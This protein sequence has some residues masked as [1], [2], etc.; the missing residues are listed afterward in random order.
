LLAYLQPPQH[1]YSVVPEPEYA[2]QDKAIVVRVIHERSL[3][4][5]DRIET[6]KRE[7]V[8]EIAIPQIDP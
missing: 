5:R 6:L 1:I 2:F 8:R 3:Y 7:V 4:Q